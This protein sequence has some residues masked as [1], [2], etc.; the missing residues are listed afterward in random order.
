MAAAEQLRNC[1]S[2][3]CC[4]TSTDG[5]GAVTWWNKSIQG[6]TCKLT[7]GKYGSTDVAMTDHDATSD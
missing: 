2:Y 3:R 4:P 6:K 5:A 7:N 1:I